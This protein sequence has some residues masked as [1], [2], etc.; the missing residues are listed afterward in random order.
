[1][2][3][4]GKKTTVT[5]AIMALALAAVLLSGCSL[6]RWAQAEPGQYIVVDE[7]AVPTMAVAREIQGLD[8]DRDQNLL[9]LTLVDGSEI[10]A[11]FV[12]R[13]RTAW[14]AGCPTNIQSTRMEVLDIVQDLAVFQAFILGIVPSLT[15]F[16]RRRYH[17]CL[18]F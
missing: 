16:A 2:I 6:D 9:V 11:S 10:V 8:I 14:P 4:T 18:L 7:G 5:V 15:V 12:P 17:V 3:S 1:M 13:D